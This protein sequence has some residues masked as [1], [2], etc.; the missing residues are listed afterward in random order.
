MMIYFSNELCNTAMH[1]VESKSA[2]DDI[3]AAKDIGEINAV[4]NAMN[5]SDVWCTYEI[6]LHRRIYADYPEIKIIE[7]AAANLAT[8]LGMRNTQ[9]YNDFENIKKDLR[10]DKYG[11]YASI[12]L[13]HGVIV[14]VEDFIESVD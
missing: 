2:V 11:I 4:L 12:L 8:A 3:K 7:D 13:K 10:R 9:T 14:K 1:I 6:N 5:P